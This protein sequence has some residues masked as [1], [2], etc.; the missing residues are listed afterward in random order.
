MIFPILGVLPRNGFQ[1]KLGK[2]TIGEFDRRGDLEL[3]NRKPHLRIRPAD[4]TAKCEPFWSF[5]DKTI[6]T[7]ESAHKELTH[8]VGDNSFETVKPHQL[9]EYLIARV[10]GKDALVLDSFAGS[11]T[12]A[13][14]VLK[15]NA[16]D[17]GSRRFIL[18]EMMDYAES[19]T[20]ERVKRV[21]AGYGEGAKAVAG[22]GGSFGFYELGP[23]LLEGDGLN[24]EVPEEKLRE[25]IWWTETRTEYVQAR[26][27]GPCPRERYLLGVHDGTAYYFCHER[28]RTVALDRTLLRRIRA[29]AESFV[30]Y[31]D[32]CR[33]PEETLR[34]GRIAFKKIPRDIAGP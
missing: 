22:T 12:T 11:G 2:D 20:A 31:A 3:I 23:A 32:V 30:V 10:C 33:L 34:R 13:H 27:G 17:G 6:G 9:I 7:G 21:I 1:W 26:A 24:E 15:M 19:I 4:D 29:K 16:E 25:Y 28:G 18:V 8:I 5:L 14:A